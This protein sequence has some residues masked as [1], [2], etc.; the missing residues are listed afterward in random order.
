MVRRIAGQPDKW[1][2]AMRARIEGAAQA[3]KATMLRRYGWVG[4]RIWSA[5]CAERECQQT[6]M[7]AKRRVGYQAIGYKVLGTRDLFSDRAVTLKEPT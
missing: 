4:Y 1:A 5:R 7:A 6:R 3:Q 2:P